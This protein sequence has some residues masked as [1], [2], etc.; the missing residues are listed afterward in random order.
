MIHHTNIKS[1]F[2]DPSV[3]MFVREVNGDLNKT[4]TSKRL[5]VVGGPP[6]SGKSLSIWWFALEYARLHPE[7]RIVWIEATKRTITVLHRNRI[8]GHSVD[9][10]PI[11]ADDF[12]F[13]DQIVSQEHYFQHLRRFG[14]LK[15]GT[16]KLVLVTAQKL[17][18]K[19]QSV[20]DHQGKVFTFPA[21]RLEQYKE[22]CNYA[23]FF[24]SVKYPLGAVQ[25]APAYV[26]P[27]VHLPIAIMGP[28]VVDLP[29]PPPPDTAPDTALVGVPDY[30]DECTRNALIEKKFY[31]AGNS[32]RWMFGAFCTTEKVKQEIEDYAL[33]I[34]SLEDAFRGYIGPYTAH[35]YNHL[36]IESGKS[37]VPIS[38]YAMR[39]MTECLDFDRFLRFS[40]YCHLNFASKH[41]SLDGQVLIIDTEK[42][43]KNNTINARVR[44]VELVNGKYI[45]AHAA[46]TDFTV[47][48]TVDFQDENH[49]PG[50]HNN[51]GPNTWFFPES[52]NQGG[53]DFVQLLQRMD[54][55][56]AARNVLRF[57][58]VHRANA[59]ALNINCI[60]MFAQ[61]F[62]HGRHEAS[63][64]PPVLNIEVAIITTTTQ[65][66]TNYKTNPPTQIIGNEA[67]FWQEDQLQLYAF[68]RIHEL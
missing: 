12:V 11:N 67:G 39:Y 8:K 54:A 43:L 64:P 20:E 30:T 42:A 19:T 48:A 26:P 66:A 2:P 7:T 55:T 14:E 46:V 49:V 56:G 16:G 44:R 29:P 22:A 17:N 32:A 34:G 40:R 5:V 33:R 3:L 50:A 51:F 63:V 25:T 47:A 6:G 27:A 4:L 60:R 59:P 52:S 65:H 31:F 68:T 57:L 36:F 23:A 13:I 53:F 45:I 24:Q 41:P 18:F 58:Q 28:P 38:Q 21:W 15:S 62:N 61:S 1:D 9:S 35:S 37:V 10:F